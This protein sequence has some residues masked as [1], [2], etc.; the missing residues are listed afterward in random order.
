MPIIIPFSTEAITLTFFDKVFVFLI[1]LYVRPKGE[2]AQ[3]CCPH[4]IGTGG[5]SCE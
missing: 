1:G 4:W 2:K 3:R 5:A